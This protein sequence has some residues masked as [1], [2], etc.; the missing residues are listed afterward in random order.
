MGRRG[1]RR[2][3]RGKGEEW[4]RAGRGGS[5]EGVKEESRGGKEGRERGEVG[6]RE[7]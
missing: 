4:D 6:G 3:V 1:G 5:G 2:R 7:E